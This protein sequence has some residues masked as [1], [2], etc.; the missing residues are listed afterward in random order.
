MSEVTIDETV[1]GRLVRVTRE[2]T[3]L[4]PT[5]EWTGCRIWQ[6]K[7]TDAGVRDAQS[8]D[9]RGVCVLTEREHT[10]IGLGE[11]SDSRRRWVTGIEFL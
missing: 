5:N 2:V 7:V 1:R 9:L 10:W 11:W 8:G 3:E 4:R 6:G